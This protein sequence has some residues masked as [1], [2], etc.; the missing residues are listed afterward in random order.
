MQRG[1]PRGREGSVRGLAGEGGAEQ[2]SC[3]TAAGGIPRA[4]ARGCYVAGRRPQ[5]LRQALKAEVSRGEAPVSQRG[6]E[7]IDLK[8]RR[9]EIKRCRQWPL[10]Q[11]DEGECR[12]ETGVVQLAKKV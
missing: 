1:A 2:I 5:L 7:L 11:L 8:L 4:S 9:F 6:H 10:H 3:V 12:F